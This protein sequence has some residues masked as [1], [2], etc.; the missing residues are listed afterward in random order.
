MDKKDKAY[1]H[2]A[3][4]E[5]SREK[6]FKTPI[7]DV[8]TVKRKSAS[9]KT[10]AF[11]LLECGDWVNIV[12][13]L[14]NETGEDCFLMVRQYRQGSQALTLEF[15]G[16]LVDHGEAPQT[17]ALRELREE[18]GYEAANVFLAGQINPNPAFM[19]NRCHTF[20]A[21]GLRKTTSQDLDENELVDFELVPTAAIA[22]D[23]GQGVYN[24][25][26]MAV[27]YFWYERWKKTPGNLSK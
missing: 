21:T 20:V 23:M 19:A 6:V 25:A 2:L 24:H 16:G 26:I 27:A 4:T 17:A 15:P 18:T 5:I 11:T 8:Y 12:P 14:K 9:G 3:W 10:A 13:L 22:K 1:P 7:F